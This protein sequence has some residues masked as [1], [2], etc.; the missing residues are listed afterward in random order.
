MLTITQ[1]VNGRAPINDDA[2]RQT[3]TFAVYSDR[4]RCFA[5]GYDDT[6]W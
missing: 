3:I 5:V 2:K 6:Q 1:V 4:I